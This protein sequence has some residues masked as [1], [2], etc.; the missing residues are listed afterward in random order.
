MSIFIGKQEAKVD[1]KGRVFVPAGYR[2]LL[3][4]DERERIVV[5]KDVDNDCIIFYPE[6]VWNR[7]LEELRGNL[8]EWSAE[9]QL[10]LLAFTEDAEW[11]D[12]DSQ[13]RV[14]LSKKHQQ[15]LSLDGSN[16]VLFIGM[17]DR[18]AVWGKTRYEQVKLSSKDLAER[19]RGRMKPLV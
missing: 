12:F 13:G 8:D 9:D 2:K 7:K 4:A 6:R 17:V 10:L 19:L 18:F 16:E 3:S 5:R 15:A 14:L 11:L 1:V